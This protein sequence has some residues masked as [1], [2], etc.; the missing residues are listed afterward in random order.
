MKKEEFYDANTDEIEFIPF[1]IETTGFKAAE[2]DFVTTFVL[3]HNGVYHIWINTDGE[4]SDAQSIRD[5]VVSASDLDNILVHVCED[6]ASLLMNVGDY[7]DSH[8]EDKTVLTAFNG[9]TYRGDTD[10]DVPFLRTRC[11]RTGVRWILDGY[12]YADIYEVFSQSSR[13]DTTVK[14]EPSLDDM[15]KADL[16][17]FIDDM[18]FDVHYDR[19]LKKEIVRAIESHNGVDESTISSWMDSQGIDADP[20]ELSSLSK[21]ELQSFIDDMSIGISYEEL[22]KDDMVKA[23]REE[24]YQEEMLLEWHEKTGRS[25]GTSEATTLDDIHEVIIEDSIHDETWKNNLPFELEVF[26]PFDPF[27]DSG[28]AVTSYKNGNFSGV[29]LH[30]FADV[31]RTV[32]LNRIMAEYAPK[33]DYSPKI[34]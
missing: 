31:A 18:G 26:T 14:A 25:I 8:T 22:S 11:F 13:F 10:F 23:I 17:Q 20:S 2:G 34:L 7:L 19:M 29:I 21:K 3:H 5:D 30:C 6:E 15:V 16:H 1:D 12:W 4:R 24:D 28:E 27:E 32:N 9:E 33:S